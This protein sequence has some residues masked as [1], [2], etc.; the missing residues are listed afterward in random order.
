M[1]AELA[2]EVEATHVTAKLRIFP[3]SNIYYNFFFPRVEAD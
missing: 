2:P 1:R 3:N